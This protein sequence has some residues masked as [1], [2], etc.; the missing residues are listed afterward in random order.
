LDKGFND[1]YDQ[2]RNPNNELTRCE[3]P[4]PR[5][6]AKDIRLVAKEA[7]PLLEKVVVYGSRL[8][9]ITGKATQTVKNTTP[10]LNQLS[11]AGEVMDR[12]GLTKAGRALEKHGGRID[13]VFPKATGG[14]ANKNMQGQYHLDDI[15]TNP[16][17]SYYPNR[18]GGQDIFSPDG[19]GVRFDAEQNL[20]GFLQ[21]RRRN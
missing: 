8:V 18:F 16:N 9:G 7:F 21:P 20:K 15:L 10:C 4:S 5:S 12:G 19:R 13:S 3:L 2:F 11:K 1:I 14:I 6:I 17:P